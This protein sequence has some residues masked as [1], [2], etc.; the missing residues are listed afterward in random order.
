MNVSNI[1]HSYSEWKRKGWPEES[2]W[3]PGEEL[4][5][6]K[7]Q[8]YVNIQY[9]LLCIFNFSIL[10]VEGALSQCP[11]IMQIEVKA[12]L[13]L[14]WRLLIKLRPSFQHHFMPCLENNEM[15]LYPLNG[16]KQLG[17]YSDQMPLCL[18]GV[19]IVFL[20][21]LAVENIATHSLKYCWNV[22]LSFKDI[23]S[24]C[25]LLFTYDFDEFLQNICICKTLTSFHS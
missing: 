17:G 18:R 7:Y 16:R 5:I 21:P 11:F 6:G 25:Y 23:P 20:Y 12:V 9:A 13:Y 8:A 4:L 24:H 2:C 19:C 14:F 22:V 15:F 10:R 1:P 3:H